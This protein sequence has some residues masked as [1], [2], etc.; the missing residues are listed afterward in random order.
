M[1]RE[2]KRRKILLMKKEK[3]RRWSKEGRGKKAEGIRT[4]EE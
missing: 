2:I 3:G 1:R 4:R